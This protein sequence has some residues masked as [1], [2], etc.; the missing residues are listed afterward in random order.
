MQTAGTRI[1]PTPEL[2]SGALDGSAEFDRSSCFVLFSLPGQE[3]SGEQRE[4][5]S[6]NHHD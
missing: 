2:D 3:R 1:P 4:E 6:Q 5:I